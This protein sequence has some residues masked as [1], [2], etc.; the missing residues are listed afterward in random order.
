MRNEVKPQAWWQLLN[1][2]TISTLSLP[3]IM[4]GQANCQKFGWAKALFGVYLGNFFLLIVGYFL[5]LLTINRPQSTIEHAT[6]FFGKHVRIL[7]ASLMIFSMLGWFGI[8]LNLMGLSLQQLLSMGGF[9]FSHLFLN[10]IFGLILAGIMS[11]GMQTLK[12]ISN[13]TV[14]LF[15]FT[16]LILILFV[17]DLTYLPRHTNFS[18]F[19]GAGLIIGA[20]INAAIDLPTFFRHARSGMDA[21]ITILLLYGF[22]VPLVESLGIY[23]FLKTGSASVLESFQAGQGL[24][25]VLWINLLTLILGSATNT[26][27]LYSALTSSYCLVSTFSFKIRIFILGFIGIFISCLNPLENL[28]SM[29]NVFGISIGSMG[30]V[31]LSSYVLEKMHVNDKRSSSFSLCSWVLGVIIGFVSYCLDWSKTNIPV[32]DAFIAAFFS[33]LVLNYLFQINEKRKMSDNL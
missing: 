5:T 32:L 28:E 33:N 23:L 20:N 7:F 12:W 22:V 18:Y 16:I 17:K 4:V 8:E 24:I 6:D 21:I 14:P 13:I 25:W 11:F 15:A 26:T 27:N 9:H 1:I 10:I 3:V 29:L 2:Q 30:S 31:I 19:G